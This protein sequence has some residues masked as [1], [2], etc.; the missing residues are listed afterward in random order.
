VRDYDPLLALDGGADGLEPYRDFALNLPRLLTPQ[1]V[2]I[3]EI[4][5]GQEPD[6]TALMQQ[7]GLCHLGTRYDLG[8]HAR[9]VIFA[10]RG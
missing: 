8:G 9:A 1:G 10:G 6:V 3:L 7:A 2:I 5:A 4:G